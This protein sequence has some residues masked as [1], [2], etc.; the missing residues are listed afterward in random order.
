MGVSNHQ[1]NGL[2]PYLSFAAD[3]RFYR[4][5]TTLRH[6]PLWQASRENLWYIPAEGRARFTFSFS[7]PLR[8][9]GKESTSQGMDVLEGRVLLENWEGLVSVERGLCCQRGMRKIKTTLKCSLLS[10]SP[11]ACSPSPKS[12]WMTKNTP[13]KEPLC[14]N[15]EVSFYIS[16]PCQFW[17][18]WLCF[19]ILS[20]SF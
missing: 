1:G 20:C 6:V 8:V 4:C 7:S 14:W 9:C 15:D 17:P 13:Q 11:L 5:A 3:W 16:L 19:P 18:S 12:F 2:V 10:T